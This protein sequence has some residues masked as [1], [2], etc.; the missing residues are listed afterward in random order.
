MSKLFFS[1]EKV[2][3][4][5]W[6]SEVEQ[7]ILDTGRSSISMESVVEFEGKYYRLYWEQGATE[8]Q[9]NEFYSQEATQ[10]ERKTKT[11]EVTDWFPV[12]DDND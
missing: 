10:V 8:M 4:L 11:V 2:E 12:G 1:E 7:K 5:I 6:E 9:E 3:E